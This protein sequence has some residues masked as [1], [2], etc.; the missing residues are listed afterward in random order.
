MTRFAL[1]TLVLLA[2]LFIAVQNGDGDAQFWIL[3]GIEV[4]PGVQDD[5]YARGQATWQIVL[6]LGLLALATQ[7]WAWS[8]SYRSRRDLRRY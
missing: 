7:A 8:T 1:P 3:P 5:L 2:A 4:L 6:G